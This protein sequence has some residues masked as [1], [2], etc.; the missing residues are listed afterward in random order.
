MIVAPA[1]A[2]AAG[3]SCDA[4]LSSGPGL[5]RGDDMGKL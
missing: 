5:R 2:G 4:R 1:E 3:V